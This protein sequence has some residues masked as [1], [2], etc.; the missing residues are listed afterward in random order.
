MVAAAGG[1]RQPATS[2]I[3]A[4]L[5]AYAAARLLPQ[6][7]SLAVGVEPGQLAAAMRGVDGDPHVV[8]FAAVIAEARRWLA[9]NQGAPAG[10]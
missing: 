2:H 8:V 9:G 4:L 3:V 7:A 5:G 1:R 6:P 10:Q